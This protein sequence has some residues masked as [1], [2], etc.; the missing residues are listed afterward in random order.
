[1]RCEEAAESGRVGQNRRIRRSYPR[2]ENGDRRRRL[3]APSRRPPAAAAAPTAFPLKRA[4][5]RSGVS[6][7]ILKCKREEKATKFAF[8]VGEIQHFERLRG[9]EQRC[10]WE[11]ASVVLGVRSKLPSAVVE[12]IQDLL[13]RAW[14]LRWQVLRDGIGLYTGAQ[15][16]QQTRGLSASSWRE[17]VA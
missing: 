17:K 7:H 2:G 6:A 1:M 3:P 5:H 11:T 12:A 10:G 8:T 14:T 9:G 15:Q 4:D 16:R 13:Q